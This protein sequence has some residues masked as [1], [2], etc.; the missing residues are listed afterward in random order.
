MSNFQGKVRKR[1]TLWNTQNNRGLNTERPFCGGSCSTDKETA[2]ARYSPCVSSSSEAVLRSGTTAL[3]AH[4]NAGKG[5]CFSRQGHLVA[6]Q[7]MAGRRRKKRVR[8]LQN[9][10][11]RSLGRMDGWKNCEVQL[12]QQSRLVAFHH[13]NVSRFLCRSFNTFMQ[14]ATVLDQKMRPKRNVK[15]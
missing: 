5:L 2:P 10:E 1:S 3:I 12:L 15:V 14:R 11:V 4:L 6:M 13:D 7:I 9:L 8:L